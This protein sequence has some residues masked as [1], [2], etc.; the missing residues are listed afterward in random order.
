[1]YILVNKETNLVEGA[2]KHPVTNCV[3]H[4]L[5]EHEDATFDMVMTYKYIDGELI[6]D[7]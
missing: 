2:S 1:M 4:D 5:Y 7:E 3:G 6:K